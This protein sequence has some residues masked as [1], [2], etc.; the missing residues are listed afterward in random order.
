MKISPVAAELFHADGRRDRHEA[1]RRFS[2]FCEECLKIEPLPQSKHVVFPPCKS[3]VKAIYG[4]NGCC[5]NNNLVEIK[6]L[7][8]KLEVSR[9][10]G[11]TEGLTSRIL[12]LIKT[13]H[14]SFRSKYVFKILEN[15][16]F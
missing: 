10:F 13:N 15:R 8:L 9:H 11:G 6:T 16:P 1:K 12:A 3:I 2:Q 5:S 7:W 14:S 4:K